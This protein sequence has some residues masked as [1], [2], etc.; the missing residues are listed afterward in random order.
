MGRL[1]HSLGAGS[2]DALTPKCFYSF[3]GRHWGCDDE[4]GWR[5]ADDVLEG[6]EVLVPEGT[7]GCAIHATVRERGFCS[8]YK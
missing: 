1:F 3:L 5:A 7:G 4:T 6:S 8:Q 2:E